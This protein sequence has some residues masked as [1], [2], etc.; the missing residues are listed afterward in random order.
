MTGV[1]RFEGAV[2]SRYDAVTTDTEA[3]PIPTP[4]LPLQVPVSMERLRWS[5]EVQWCLL[6]SFFREF[7]ARGWKHD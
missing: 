6:L 3:T 2:N 5:L 7:I 1:L 4:R